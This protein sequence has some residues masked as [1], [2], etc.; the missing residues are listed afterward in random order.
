MR[1]TELASKNALMWTPDG[2]YRQTD[3]L[4]M[5]SQPAGPLANI[6][7]AQFEPSV[8]DDAKIFKRYVDDVIRSIRKDGVDAKLTEINSLHPNLKFTV[9]RP[10]NGRIPFLDMEIIN[11]NGHLSSTWYQ[12]PT[13]TGLVMNF[14]SVA[15]LCYKKSVVA[16]FVHRIHRVCSSWEH[17]HNS[18]LKAKETLERNQYPPQFFDPIIND[19]MEKLRPHTM[20]EKK[21]QTEGTQTPYKHLFRIQY[22]GRLTDSYIK[23]LRSWETSIQPVI[24]L[25]KLKSCMP[26][27]KESIPMKLVN[28]VVYQITCSGCRACNVGQ[29][30]RH[31]T[32]R[33]SEHRTRSAGPVKRHFLQCINRKPTWDDIIILCKTTR[34]TSFLET[35][36]ALY[37]REIKPSL[38][39]KDEYR[40]RELLIKF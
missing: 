1:L 39:T 25:R 2:Y 30:S 27:L 24:T 28:Q 9:E 17:L 3:G 23:K 36:E 19:T 8:R 34:N 31:L 40:S 15:P 20:E 35:L 18:L 26:S 29:T 5:G 13:D 21:Q 38:N 4:A 12:K 11:N 37:I 22:R 33:F 16:G 32:T 6:W 7:L 10:Q 14:H